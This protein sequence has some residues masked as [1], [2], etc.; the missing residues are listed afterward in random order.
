MLLTMW[1]F[2]FVSTK[3]GYLE[4]LA[5][6]KVDATQHCIPADSKDWRARGRPRLIPQ[7]G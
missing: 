2:V 7:G 1:F 5:R 3:A 6:L 4:S